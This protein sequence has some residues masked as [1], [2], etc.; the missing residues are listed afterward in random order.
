MAFVNRPFRPLV[1]PVVNKKTILYLAA[2]KYTG[3]QLDLY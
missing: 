1:T 3:M 2:D